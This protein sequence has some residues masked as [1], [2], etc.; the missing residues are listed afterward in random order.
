MKVKVKAS[1]FIFEHEDGS[2][3]EKL[4]PRDALQGLLANYEKMKDPIKLIALK[5]V[6]ITY[7]I[8]EEVVLEN[9]EIIKEVEE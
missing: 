8:P 9:G 1:R 2:I 4:A 6:K 7:D 3:T 5:N